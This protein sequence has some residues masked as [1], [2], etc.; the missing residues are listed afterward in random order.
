MQYHVIP[1]DR[2]GSQS[3]IPVSSPGRVLHKRSVKW[4]RCTW[5][6]WECFEASSGGEALESRTHFSSLP[7]SLSLSLSVCLFLALIRSGNIRRAVWTGKSQTCGER[8]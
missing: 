3:A 8:N 6:V 7:L 5:S 4:T 2:F 1:R